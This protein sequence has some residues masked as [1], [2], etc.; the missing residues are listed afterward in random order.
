MTVHL[1]SFLVKNTRNDAR[2]G[3]FRFRRTCTPKAHLCMDSLDQW[4]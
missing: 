1:H 4:S 3:D 2:M